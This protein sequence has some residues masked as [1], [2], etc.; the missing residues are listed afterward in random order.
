MNRRTFLEASTVAMTTLALPDMAS[1]RPVPLHVSGTTVYPT[2]IRPLDEALGGGI[3]DGLCLVLG[4]SASGKTAFLNRLARF[5]YGFA[6][7]AKKPTICPLTGIVHYRPEFLY[8]DWID[9]PV[10]LIDNLQEGQGHY[11]IEFRRKLSQKSSTRTSRH[12]LEPHVA[13]PCVITW[14]VGRASNRSTESGY[15]ETGPNSMLF[16]SNVIIQIHKLDIRGHG[17]I[18]V[19]KNHQSNFFGELTI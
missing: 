3:P 10:A 15:V 13:E 6:R 9:R 14:N 1:A 17:R 5:P 16:I 7:H 4:L 18:D 19:I 8:H 11:P 12:V 2:G